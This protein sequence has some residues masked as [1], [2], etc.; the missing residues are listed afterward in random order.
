MFQ[1]LIGSLEAAA[2]LAMSMGTGKSF[3]FLIGSLEACQIPEYITSLG[4]EFQFL[5]GSL[6]AQELCGSAWVAVVEVS[7]PHR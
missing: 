2:M 4:S 7:I 1:F 6:E 3:Q 5:I